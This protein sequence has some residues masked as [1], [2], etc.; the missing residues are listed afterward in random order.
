MSARSRAVIA[1]VCF[2]SYAAGCGPGARDHTDAGRG[3]AL[4]DSRGTGSDGHG[5][6][7]DSHS[8]GSDAGDSGSCGGA[9]CYAGQS[10]VSDQC[11]FTTCSGAHVPGDYAMIQ[12]AINAL[13]NGCGQGTICLAAQTYAENLSVTTGSITI[14]GVSPSQTSITALDMPYGDGLG[15]V[16]VSLTGVSIHG[17]TIRTGANPGNGTASFTAC[18]IGTLDVAPASASLV[19]SL[20]GVDLSSGNTAAAITIG[21]SDGVF[22][23][24]V[25]NSYIHDSGSGVYFTNSTESTAT[26]SLAFLDNTFENAG[27]ALSTPEGCVD[28]EVCGQPSVSYYN[29]LFIDNT[30]AVDTQTNEVVADG[31]NA[32]F[33]N[34]TNYGGIAADGSGYVK[35]DP[36][37]D[38]STTPPGLKTGSPCRGAGD[39]SHASTH[40]FWGR[41]RGPTIDIGAVQ[42]SP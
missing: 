33:A 23:I 24:T 5:T 37:L 15:N 39:P 4:S 42:S 28:L 40:D 21:Q 12:A 34:T 29:N 38:T 8:S 22:S 3:N 16:G 25:E 7:S 9:I 19:V 11:A 27:T 2:S 20:D 14:E 30:L 13:T 32:L 35:S 10:C 36:L 17:V 6:G 26:A 18:S 31:N 1:L 41:P